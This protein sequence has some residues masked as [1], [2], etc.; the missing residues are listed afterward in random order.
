MS[1]LPCV[2]ESM[3]EGGGSS[4]W[5]ALEIK[6]ALIFVLPALCITLKL[7]CCMKSSHRLIVPPESFIVD[8]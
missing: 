7:N 2:M 5:V 6:S 3:S 1:W 4:I 8:Q